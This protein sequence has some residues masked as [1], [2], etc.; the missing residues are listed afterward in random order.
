MKLR[1]PRRRAAL[2]ALLAAIAVPAMA[3]GPASPLGPVH[4]S[5]ARGPLRPVDFAPFQGRSSSEILASPSSGLE[6]AFVLY[7]RLAPRAARLGSQAWSVDHT[8][9]VLKG[10]ARVE[11]GDE[12]FTVKPETLVLLPAGTPHRIWNESGEQVDLIEVATPAPSRDLASLVRPATPRHVANAAALVRQAPPLGELAG[13][14]GHASLNERVLA[15]RATGSP[16]V[17]ERLNDMLPGGGRTATH[18]HPFDQVYFIRKGEMAVQY[19][20]SN[21]TAR[22]NTLVVLPVGVA[23][24][25]LNQGQ[26][27]Q[28]VVTLLLPE[29]EPGKPMGANVAVEVPRPRG[30]EGDAPRAP[31]AQ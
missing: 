28:S 11:V 15:S 2:A 19:G 17:L 26:G 30:A 25:N 20:M 1:H 22:D 8:Y 7:T 4:L 16:N 10:T 6:S 14:T 29:S 31:A 3:A 5:P 12:R 13:G 18:L 21:F 9:L 24:N 23:H 27:V